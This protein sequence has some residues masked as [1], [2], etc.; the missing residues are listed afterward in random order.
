[1]SN[2]LAIQPLTAV[3]T[4]ADAAGDAKPIAVRAS[5]QQAHAASTSPIPNPSLRLDPVLGLVVIEFRSD[6]G[7]VARSIPSQ[8]QLE[9]YQRWETSRFGPA[10][11]G[12]S[13]HPTS[14]PRSL[15]RANGGVLSS[16]TETDPNQPK[17]SSLTVRST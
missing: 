5:P 3:R 14:E 4:G 2:D 12:R 16:R 10:P 11:A 9:A 6:T 1:M 17:S 15:S 7:A 13:D 8:R